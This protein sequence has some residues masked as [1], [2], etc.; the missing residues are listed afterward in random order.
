[1]T[2]FD[3]AIAA[4]RARRAR[5]RWEYVFAVLFWGV[6]LGL[7]L[8]ATAARAPRILY[9]GDWTGPMQIFAADP[10]GRAP[11]AL[12]LLGKHSAHG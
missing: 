7:L 4:P 2:T 10:S 9:A 5:L 8:I 6:V 12:D 1:M 11:L 3:D